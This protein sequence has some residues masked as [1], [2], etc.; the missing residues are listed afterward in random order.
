MIQFYLLFSY[1]D[2]FVLLLLIVGLCVIL[3]GLCYT[4]SDTKEIQLYFDKV[5]GYECGFDPFSDAREQF[6]IKFYLVSILFL[7]FDLELVFFLPWLLCQK[8]IVFNGFL[9]MFTFFCILF[10]G[11]CHEWRKSCLNWSDH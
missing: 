3:L 5:S 1:V 7:I 9:Y 11:F 2:L 8:V 10:A 4:L 6:N